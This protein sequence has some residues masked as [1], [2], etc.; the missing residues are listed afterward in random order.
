MTKQISELPATS[1]IED[2]DLIA[3]K[4]GSNDFKATIAQLV[5]LTQGSFPAADILSLLQTVDSDS[6]GLNANYLQSK[7]AAFFRN[8]SNLN[9]GVVP[10]TQLPNGSMTSSVVST[11]AK[12]YVQFPTFMFGLERIMIQFGVTDY[13]LSDRD[14]SVTFP[15]PFASGLTFTSEPIVLLTPQ[16]KS[17]E[18]NGSVSSHAGPDAN[19]ELDVRLWYTSLSSFKAS[20][21]RTTGGNSDYVRANWIAIGKY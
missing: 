8:A 5:A 15:V 20:S 14:I 6:S 12:H 13:V 10:N 9:A 7:D 3:T 2:T 21:I 1:G 18:Y 19:V 16:C 17:S 4:K 11:S